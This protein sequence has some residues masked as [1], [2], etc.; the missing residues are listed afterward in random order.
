MFTLKELILDCLSKGLDDEAIVARV[1]DHEEVKT[2]DANGV[3][4]V[5]DT[6]KKEYDLSKA[7]GLRKEETKEAEIKAEAAGEVEKTVEGILKTKGFDKFSIGAETVKH[8]NPSTG[9]NE[10]LTDREVDGV[11]HFGE[12][13]KY[14]MNGN[15]IDAAAVSKDID[16]ENSKA[17]NIAGTPN[18]GGYA[19][20]TPVDN[21]IHELIYAQSVAM[22]NFNTDVIMQND[23]I[24][25]VMANAVV[26]WIATED[27]AASQTTPAFSAP[28]TNMY[29]AGAFSAISNKL[30]GAASADVVAAFM[31]SYAAAFARFVDAQIFIG[32]MTGNSDLLDGLVWNTQGAAGTPI[33]LSALGIDDV[34][35]MLASISDEAQNVKLFGNRSVKFQLGL[36]ENTGGINYF[37]QVINGGNFA[38]FGHDFVENTKITN[39]LNVGGDDSTGGSDTAIL[40]VDCN[41][42]MLGVGQ[43][44]RIDTSTDYLFTKDQVVIRGIKDLGYSVLHGSG[45]SLQVLELTGA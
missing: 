35:T 24:Y 5:L 39:V 21:Q 3:L 45:S 20:P 12:M 7:L 23:K 4:E 15:E 30:I 11:E 29:R 31:R 41:A 32:N 16:S 1:K 27:T 40:A 28:T 8:Y 44:T 10:V 18:V 43:R 34:Q 14:L 13:L 9:K 42:V 36:D 6:A 26:D 38:P 2:L 25:P 37:P 19:V 33:A 17:A 22:N